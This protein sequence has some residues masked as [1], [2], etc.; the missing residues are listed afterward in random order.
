MNTYL[1]SN[2]ERIKQSIIDRNIR[3]AKEMKVADFVMGHGYVFCEVS[4]HS[5]GIIDIS[6]IISVKYAKETGRTELCWDFRNMRF[7]SRTQH[8]ILDAKTNL[9]REQIYIDWN[10]E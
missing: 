2:G 1:T 7:L 10:N 4:K 6:H 5:E 9:E 8:E 3:K